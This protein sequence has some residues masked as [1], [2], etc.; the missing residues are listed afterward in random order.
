MQTALVH[1][2]GWTDTVHVANIYKG[3]APIFLF[4]FNESSL[5]IYLSSQSH[6]KTNHHFLYFYMPKT[7]SMN[8]VEG[9]E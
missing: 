3:T 4:H 1:T 5:I 7:F 6:Y 8:K 2:D 9:I